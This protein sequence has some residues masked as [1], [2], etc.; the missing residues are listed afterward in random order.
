MRINEILTE[1]QL[2]ELELNEGPIGSAV[3]AGLGAMV[4]GPAGAAVGGMAGNWAGDKLGKSKLGQAVKGAWTGAKAGYKA[5]MANKPGDAA[6]DPNSGIPNTATSP[7]TPTTSTPATS[8]PAT[9]TAGTTA[10][11][12]MSNQQAKVGMTQ[13]RDI[14]SKLNSKQL[15]QVKAAIDQR[16]QALAAR[17]APAAQPAPPATQQPAGQPNLQVQQGGSSATANPAVGTKATGS[18][19]QSYTWKGAQWV[20]DTTGRIASGAIAQQLSGNG[21][22]TAESIEFTSKF[23]GRKI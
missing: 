19:G 13:I 21:R 11:P 12:A 8:T 15:T 16:A 23:L 3:G 10:Q 4:G 1:N 7:A 14:V 2:D 6:A 5:A 9:S 22:R 18:D 17:R 20:S